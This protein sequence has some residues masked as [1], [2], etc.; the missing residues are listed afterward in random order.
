MTSM[1]LDEKEVS[2]TDNCSVA[3]TSAATKQHWMRKIMTKICPK[4]M[5]FKTEEEEH[6]ERPSCKLTIDKGIELFLATKSKKWKPS[7]KIFDSNP[8]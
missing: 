3:R 5:V 8:A 2:T 7:T 1:E 6:D 4:N